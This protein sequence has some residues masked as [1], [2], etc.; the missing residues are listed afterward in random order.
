M[1]QI[2]AILTGVVPA[3]TITLNWAY[4]RTKAKENITKEAASTYYMNDY[5]V[6]N[7]QSELEQKLEFLSNRNYK[8]IFIIDEL[9]KINDQDLTSVI[10]SLKLLFKPFFRK[11]T[12]KC[13]LC[14]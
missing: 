9:D 7:L 6:S 10:K 1:E 4:K 5:D 11:P 3:A 13:V 12:C 8:V 2:L 14:V